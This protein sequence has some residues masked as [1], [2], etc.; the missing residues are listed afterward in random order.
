M[1]LTAEYPGAIAVPTTNFFSGR[2]GYFGPLTLINH[3]T[4]GFPTA[5]AVAKYF[6]TGP[7]SAH[8]VVAKDGTVYQCVSIYDSCWGEGACTSKLPYW[9]YKN[10]DGSQ[11]NGN[12]YTIGVEHHKIST[13]NS[14]DLTDAQYQASARLA[15]WLT[16]KLAI[17][18]QFIVDTKGGITGHGVFDPVHRSSVNGAGGCP[19][20]FQWEHWL[21]LV[22]S[23]P[24]ALPLSPT[25]E[26]CNVVSPSQFE[27]DET[28]FACV[29]YVAAMSKYMTHPHSP[30][31]TNPELIDTW[32]DHQYDLEYGSHGGSQTGG[33][34]IPDA[35]R[36]ITAAGH[37]YSDVQITP[38]TTQ[39][40]D[41]AHLRACF[42]QRYPAM[43]T[44]LESSAYDMQLGKNPYIDHWT[45]SGNHEVFFTGY[46]SDGNLL[47]H[48]SAA[49]SGDLNGVNHILPQPRH[50]RASTIEIHWAAAINSWWLPAFPA[51][52]D[53]TKTIINPPTHPIQEDV[54]P[55][56]HHVTNPTPG[57]VKG[58]SLLWAS[59]I[60]DPTR[61]HTGEL[62]PDFTSDIAT[63]W[64]QAHYNGFSLGAP[65][66]GEY[67]F[68]DWSD[69]PIVR[70]DFEG[71]W[72]ENS[73]YKTT[74]YVYG[75]GE[76]KYAP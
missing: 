28:Q 52:W 57:Q 16:A 69:N 35:H 24:V 46:D 5:L 10:A 72:A 61:L 44:I 59:F 54:M 20:T 7:V 73:N 36:L 26:V 70:Q 27:P 67:P 9:P 17:P 32:A 71:G 25:G 13:D 11:L 47:I 43:L 38:M 64:C 50:Y 23:V 29:F 75:W 56:M 58:A 48:D 65:K 12:F 14:E 53:A 49:I 39:A 42:D 62:A 51:N 15:Q 74:L 45:P 6:Q 63:N 1:L 22:Q 30:N 66:S 4:A 33:A 34:S 68:F 8:F 2:Q 19:G 76:L 21:S 3:A 40:S 31:A 18:R 37:L 60:P 55:V 41:L